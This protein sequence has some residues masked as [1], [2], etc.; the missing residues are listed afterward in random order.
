CSRILLQALLWRK[1]PVLSS[2]KFYE[3]TRH[4]T[5]FLKVYIPI[6]QLI[7]HNRNN[8]ISISDDELP[9]I[10]MIPLMAFIMNK[11]TLR[12]KDNVKGIILKLKKIIV[13]LLLLGKYSSIS[14][15]NYSPFIQILKYIDDE[16]AFYS[17][18]SMEAIM[19]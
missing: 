12:P 5:N 16:D 15:K 17:N 8:L 19:N 18:P 7:P 2:M 13:R 11:E 6:A 9:N 14:W 3:I 4:S 10:R 1:R